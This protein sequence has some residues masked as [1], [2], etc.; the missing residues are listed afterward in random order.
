M[1]GQTEIENLLEYTLLEDEKLFHFCTATAIRGSGK[2]GQKKDKTSNCVRL[3]FSHFSVKSHKYRLRKMNQ[4]DA[5]KKL[6]QEIALNRKYSERKIWEKIPVELEGFLKNKKITI[7]KNNKYYPFF[8]GFWNDLLVQFETME[9]L[10]DFLQVSKS[11][12]YKWDKKNYNLLK[13][14]QIG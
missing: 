8:L 4:K 5:I 1:R 6:K 9:Q 14:L 13:N 10:V 3:S 7:H 12:I 11:Q 2:G